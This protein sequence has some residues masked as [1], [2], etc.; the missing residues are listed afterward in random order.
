MLY[1]SWGTGDESDVVPNN[2]RY[3][4]R[5]ELL[6]A[7]RASSSNWAQGRRC[8][9]GEWTRGRASTSRGRCPATSAAATSTTAAPGP[10]D[11]SA[12]HRGIE[13]SVARA[14]RRVVRWA[15]ARM[16]ARAARR[17]RQRQP[18]RPAPDQRAGLHAEAA[19][20]AT[21]CR[22]CPGL[23]LLANGLY[24]SD[25]IVLPDNSLQHP[26]R[27]AG[28]TWALRYEQPLGQGTLIWRAGIDNLFNQNAWRESP[29]QFGHVV[30]VPD[31][32]AHAS[33][34]RC[35]PACRHAE[36]PL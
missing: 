21:A 5:G 33:R 12:V 11:G 36:R 25:R 29:Y 15:A 20:A 1:A 27:D 2:P 16:A 31:G 19:A 28:W 32:A 10:R 24:E 26:Q 6:P 3:I 8:D 23:E 34:C 22:A 17:Q 4:N 14:L 7:L 30:P 18:E 35:R 9:N 13:A